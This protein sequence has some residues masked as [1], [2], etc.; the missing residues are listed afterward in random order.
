MRYNRLY[1][2]ICRGSV[3]ICWFHIGDNAKEHGNCFFIIIGYLSI[4]VI[5]GEYGLLLRKFV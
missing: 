5:V 1:I 2:Y 4:G 3:G